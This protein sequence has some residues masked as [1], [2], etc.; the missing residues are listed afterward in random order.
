MSAFENAAFKNNGEDVLTSI[1]SVDV[2]QDDGTDNGT[3]ITPPHATALMD[4]GEEDRCVHC[5]HAFP[6]E[7]SLLLHYTRHHSEKSFKCGYC[8]RGYCNVNGLRVHSIRHHNDARI[9]SCGDCNARF[10]STR[11]LHT[12]THLVHSIAFHQNPKFLHQFYIPSIVSLTPHTPPF[13]KRRSEQQRCLTIETRK[14][15]HDKYLTL[16]MYINQKYLEKSQHLTPNSPMEGEVRYLC[17]I[18]GYETAHEWILPLHRK[19][20]DSHRA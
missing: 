6:T 3:S 10:D 8:G 15:R 18:C 16:K 5:G 13:Y 4:E 19:I 17:I 20:H 9:Y 7:R 2:V 11:L 1:V 14:A 12:H